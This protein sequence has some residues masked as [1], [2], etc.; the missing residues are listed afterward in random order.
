MYTFCLWYRIGC[1]KKQKHSVTRVLFCMY[2]RLEMCRI[3]PH[4]RAWKQELA[5]TLFYTSYQQP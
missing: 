1:E 4:F 3:G 2:N 5:F